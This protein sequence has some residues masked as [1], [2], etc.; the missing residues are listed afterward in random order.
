MTLPTPEQPLPVDV[1]AMEQAYQDSL[2]VKRL[3]RWIRQLRIVSPTEQNIPINGLYASQH[4]ALRDALKD[5]LACRQWLKGE[6]ARIEGIGAF[7]RPLL[8]RAMFEKTGKAHDTSALYFR[9]WY[10]YYAPNRGISWGRHPPKDK[11]YF[12]VPL[13]EAALNNFTEGEGLN[14][15]PKDN[16]IVD[17]HSQAVDTL[18][19]PAFARMCRQ[20]D[21]GGRYQR[22]LDS[23]LKAPASQDSGW[24][25]MASTLARLYRS[26]MV[27]DACRAKSEGVLTGAELRFILDLCE[28]GRPGTFHESK[29]VARQ[30]KVFGCELQQIVVLD[31]LHEGW[32]FDFSRRII[33]YVPGDP[34][35]PWSIASNLETFIRKTLGKRLRKAQY[36]TFFKRFVRR[37]DS[38]LFFSRVARELEDVADGATR[39]MDQHMLDYPLPLFDHLAA[40]RIAHIKDDA[41]L[42][43][44]PVAELDRQVQEAHRKRLAVEGWTLLTVAG[45]FIPALN[46]ILLAVMVWDLLGELFHGVE[47]WREGDTKAAMDHL[48]T[49]SKELAVIGVTAVI[50][51]EGSRAW[52]ALDKWV[53]ARLED[54]TQKLWNGDLLPYRSVK[55]P[56]GS[57]ADKAGIYRA[58]DKCWTIIDGHY[59]E[60]AQRPDGEWQLTPRG[61]HG[62]LLRHNDAGAWRLWIEQPASWTDAH[63]MFR[64]LGERF[65]RLDDHQIDQAMAIHG[66]DTDNLRA[67]HVYARAPEA[68]L[69][70]TVERLL[71]DSRVQALLDG[72]RA[73]RGL[74][75][76]ALLSKARAL[77]G[78]TESNG[79]ALA[80]QI[81]A[82]RRQLFQQLYLERQ[83]PDDAAVATLRHTFPSLHRLAA[84]ELV[85]GLSLEGEQYQALLKG[86]VPFHMVDRARISVLR[87]RVARACEAL[88]IDTPQTLD[89]AKAALTLL[90]TLDVRAV[91]PRWRLYDND[92]P[93][94][95]LTTDGGGVT[96]RL[97]HKA[98]LFELEDALGIELAGPGELFEIMAGAF[99]H[100]DFAAL[101]ISQPYAQGLR[102]SLARQ[103]SGQ[104]NLI[105]QVLGKDS[106]LPWVLAPKRLVDGR[107]GYPLGGSQGRF[108]RPSSRPRAFAVRLRDLYPAYSDEQIDAWLARLH[109]S[110]RDT[111]NELGMLE[112]QSRLLEKHLKNWE[113][114]GALAGEKDERKKFRK[115]MMLCWRE[116]IPY[117][118]RVPPDHM[119]TAWQFTGHELRS[120]PELGPQFSFPHVTELALGSLL[121]KT[122]PAQFLQCFPNLTILE[123]SSNRLATLPSCLPQLGKL[124]VL[125]LSDNRILLDD[126]Q[127]AVLGICSQLRYLNLS[128]NDLHAG[129]S[130]VGMPRLMELRV[131]NT[132]LTS[133]PV[134]L[135][136]CSDLYLLDASGNA[137]TALPAGFLDS[138][139]WQ[140][141]YVE[142]SGNPLPAHQAADIQAEWGFPESSVVPYRLRW[143]DRLEGEK[144]EDLASLW[145]GIEQM[146]RSA[147]FLT[148]LAQLTRSRDFKH[149]RYGVLLA[150]RVLELMESM[151]D[152]PQLAEEIYANALV[153]HCADNATVVFGQLEIRKLVWDAEHSAP[154]ANQEGVLVRLARRLWRQREVDLIALREAEAAGAGNESVEWAL[155]YSIRL[156]GELDLP[157]NAQSMLHEGIPDLDDAAVARMRDRVAENETADALATWMVEQPFWRRFM[158]K[159]YA[160]QLEV[161]QHLRSQ[162]E[163]DADESAAARLMVV[164]RQWTEQTE[165]Q[166]AT[167]ALQRWV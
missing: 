144:R 129:F 102:A 77:P 57:V 70:D 23:I 21:L 15:Q 42:I 52:A 93:Q 94:P 8:Q 75:D 118:T 12:E 161:P 139:L 82:K 45:L 105:A 32:M 84:G 79:P 33:V 46:A 154:V 119:A 53:P 83:A 62:P 116:L 140:T 5:S 14:E 122:M 159:H 151:Y 4:E 152:A 130:V 104:S 30:L 163:P 44:T 103:V 51:R 90:Q 112:Q 43:A 61:G 18:A 156:R 150:V 137:L 120:L 69:V 126:A 88:F 124:R 28:E 74:D 85:S 54:G 165:L 111:E 135:L 92:A 101:G 26:T 153:E 164:I 108:T 121:L 3:P 6:L 76:A 149:P 87:I 138:G 133:L 64:R 24:Q 25:D 123:L 35:G 96:Y 110:G 49:V 39:E 136:N 11:D 38:Q 56:A 114:Q 78:V 142:L 147:N 100:E 145:I 34:D 95:L 13:I 86:T 158:E 109:T 80:E 37:R 81:W 89:L 27:I 48:L 22:H 29:V 72:L 2:I 59:Y 20:L 68:E 146:D 73:G 55:P 107:I 9:T 10:T 117:Q 63:R 17:S 157:G 98:G 40:A 155:A 1:L 148:L 7:A 36:Q 166:L 131:R 134:G 91:R 16:C 31:V 65:A 132:R 167:E 66:L 160:R 162:L 60:I 58:Q 50:W 47:E 106:Q 113:W 125:D 143:L 67:L 127:A 128:N 97:V 99:D 115:A 141:G 19:A 41:A 71:I